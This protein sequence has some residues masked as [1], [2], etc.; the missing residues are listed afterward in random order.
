MVDEQQLSVRAKDTGDLGKR[1]FRV[2]DGAQD[3][4]CDDGVD[5]RIGHRRSLGG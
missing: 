1:A 4:R 2:I 3:E 5:R